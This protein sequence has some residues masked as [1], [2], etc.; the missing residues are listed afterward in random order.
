[1]RNVLLA[2]LLLGGTQRLQAQAPLRYTQIAELP[3]SLQQAWQ[4]SESP[5]GRVIALMAGRSLAQHWLFDRQDRTTRRLENIAGLY[6]VW[7]RDGRQFA[8]SA[9]EDDVQ[10][11]VAPVDDGK[12]GAPRRVSVGTA[13][14]PVYSPDGSQLAYTVFESGC[15]GGAACEKL[16]IV[17][18]RGGTA[19]EVLSLPDTQGQQIAAIGWT[20]SGWL[21]YTG[22]TAAGR[23]IFRVRTSGGAP[24]QLATGIVGSI[25]MLSQ[26]D[27]LIPVVLNASAG[28]STRTLVVYD[29]IGR[30]VLRGML[31]PHVGAIGWSSAPA[32][33]VG[34][35]AIPGATVYTMPVAGG[36]PRRISGQGGEERNAHWSPDGLMLAFRVRVEERYAPAV[37]NAD[38]TARRVFTEAP[39]VAAGANMPVWSPDGRWL[40]YRSGIVSD[41]VAVVVL[42]VAT[43]RTRTL[44]TGRPGRIGWRTDGRAV[45]FRSGNDDIR[46]VL[47]DGTGERLLH[48]VRDISHTI[49]EESAWATLTDDEL[50]LVHADGRTATLLRGVR[51]PVVVSQDMRQYAGVATP[52]P[53]AR[54]PSIVIGG[55]GRSPATV[56]LTGFINP[57]QLQWDATGSRL[58]LRAINTEGVFRIVSIPAGGGSIRQLA[59]PA[60]ADVAHF[61]LSPDGS[62]IVYSA[63]APSRQSIVEIP[64][65]GLR[66]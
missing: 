49:V 15:E 61:S 58:Y 37:V 33:L 38:G 26:Q 28:A 5:N 42:D 36:T 23:S 11:W 34:V 1:M 29:S 10:V 56:E 9:I 53:E 32:K 59:L 55:S 44:A 45:V 16:V 4:I 14:D 50:K 6:P 31:P 43:G 39:P 40:A 22:G 13:M 60:D 35:Q 7:S 63:E 57:Q 62:T 19:R 17:P 46:E 25:H 24:Q 47:L 8:F 65:D 66:R 48:T 52:V 18:A 41:A 64:L 27:D 2:L 3:S 20:R 54:W 21:Y 30:D 12:V 51:A